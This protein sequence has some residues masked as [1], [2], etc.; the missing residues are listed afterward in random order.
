[1]CAYRSC[2]KL[3]EVCIFVLVPYD[4]TK[5]YIGSPCIICGCVSGVNKVGN[6]VQRSSSWILS[7]CLTWTRM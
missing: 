3:Q 5:I 1:M 2:L 7:Y 4:A 6:H